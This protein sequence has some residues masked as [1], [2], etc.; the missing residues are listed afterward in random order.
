[1]APFLSCAIYPAGPAQPSEF[2][3]YM[4]GATTPVISPAFTVSGGVRMHYDLS[5][6]TVGNHTVTAKAAKTTP[7]WGRLVSSSSPPFAFTRPSAPSAPT[8]IVL[9][10][11]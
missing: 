8:D 6:M 1:M 4:D 9:I 2:E 10:T 7:E 3:I 5:T 11:S